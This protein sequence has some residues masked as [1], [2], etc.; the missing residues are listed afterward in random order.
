MII[1][2]IN[3]IIGYIIYLHL[4]SFFKNMDSIDPTVFKTLSVQQ[5]KEIEQKLLNLR[6][7]RHKKFIAPQQKQHLKPLIDKFIK[8][9]QQE[10][11]KP[12]NDTLK[13]LRK[14][15]PKTQYWQL[16][17]NNEVFGPMT[18]NQFIQTMIKPV[19]KP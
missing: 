1:I 6:K 15:M 17:G 5:L 10:H 9:L 13:E 19:T 4:I 7:E 18:K 2:H 12:I 8:P 14:S 11:I 3:I 16:Q